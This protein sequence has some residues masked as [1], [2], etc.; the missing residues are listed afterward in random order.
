MCGLYRER[1]ESRPLERWGRG[2]SKEAHISV[3]LRACVHNEQAAGDRGHPGTTLCSRIRTPVFYQKHSW[4][5]S[6]LGVKSGAPLG[7][8]LA[9][10]GN[11]PPWR[12]VDGVFS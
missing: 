2:D 7:V 5:H 8:I 1:P 10:V 12:R 11:L 4:A 3:R 6:S 9:H